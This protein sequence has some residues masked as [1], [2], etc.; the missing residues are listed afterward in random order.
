M[1]KKIIRAVINLFG[2]DVVR[3]QRDKNNIKKLLN[4][5]P[6]YQEI[7][8]ENPLLFNTNQ[9]LS[10]KLYTTFCVTKYIVEN[11]IEG[12]FVECGVYKG[13]MIA[14]MSATLLKLGV[15]DRKIYLF[16]TFKGMT[17]I[18]RYD[19]KDNREG[20]TYQ[21]NLDRQNK[22]QKEDYNLR[23]YSP[24]EAVL[25]YILQTGYSESNFIFK[26]GDV[27]DTLPT[28]EIN[29]IS[30]LRLDTDWYESTKHELDHLYQLLVR[31]GVF[32]Q[33]DY[34]SWAGA[35]KA[36]DEFFAE[37]KKKPLLFRMGKSEIAT[38]KL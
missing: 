6:L 36:V 33:D 11:D 2:F 37:N 19:Y 15:D 26:E 35:R 9:Q 13:Q 10:T 4:T 25:N 38:I 27:L 34:G 5:S 1:I 32:V 30:F 3:Y 7:R 16:D 22:M 17:G 31:G 28:S 18:S 12:D 24:R 23:C 29:K 21:Y 8:K 14:M 20:Y